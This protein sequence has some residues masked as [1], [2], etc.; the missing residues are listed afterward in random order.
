MSNKV[1]LLSSNY[2]GVEQLVARRAHNPKVVGSS[3]APA[4]RRTKAFLNFQK[5]F[6][7]FRTFQACL[8][9]YETEKPSEARPLFFLLS[10]PRSGPPA[11]GGSPVLQQ[12]TIYSSKSDGLD[13]S[14]LS[15]PHSGPSA[16][17]KVLLFKF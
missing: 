12:I 4:T 11:L 14:L 5:G 13:D 2:R 17:P 6:F 8:E 10:P 3:P 7:R 9:K 15:L 1:V 16:S